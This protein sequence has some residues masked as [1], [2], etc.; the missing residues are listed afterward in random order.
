MWTRQAFDIL[1]TTAGGQIR[2]SALLN[3][4][5]KSRYS[6]TVRV[7]DGRGGSDTAN[8][9]DHRHGPARRGAD[10]A[11]RADGDGSIEHEPAGD[12]DGARERGPTRHRL[13]LPV[14][15]A[16][17]VL[18]RCYRHDDLGHDGHDLGSH[19]Q[20]V[21]RRRC[22]GEER[23]GHERLVGPGV[24]VDRPTRSEQPAR[25]QRGRERDVRNV[26]ARAAPGAPVGD[27]VTA[28]DADSGDTLTYS[29]EGTDAASFDVRST[30][31]QLVTRSGVALT[32][33]STY[34]VTVVADDGTDSA[35]IAVT[36]T[37]TIGRQAWQG[38]PVAVEAGR[39][40]RR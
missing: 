17:R 15:G 37:A 27:P 5:E 10:S 26:S 9:T 14:Q 24:R 16:D 32:D 12:L 28:T 25:V 6:V 1:S 19:R 8:V 22:A 2:T 3:H 4:E 13:R 33:A 29:L 11:R 20:H 7:T 31:G 35:T 34:T 18:D 38:E 30:T 23:R 39:S 40:G 21:L 36:I